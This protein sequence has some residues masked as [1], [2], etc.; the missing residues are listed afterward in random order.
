MLRPQP[1][2]DDVYMFQ[3]GCKGGG[4]GKGGS[5]PPGFDRILELENVANLPATIDRNKG[6]MEPVDQGPTHPV[7][8]FADPFMLE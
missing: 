5:C 7:C 4:G 1:C 6:A 3:Q 2:K 8:G